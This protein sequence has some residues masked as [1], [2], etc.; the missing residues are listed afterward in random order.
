[1]LEEC[2]KIK[3]MKKKKKIS[4]LNH[5]F[6]QYQI[7]LKQNLDKNI[8]KIV[9][10]S[11]VL[12]NM[13]DNKKKA[14]IVGNGG[15]SAIASH[16]S[17][18]LTK[19]AKIRCINF[20]EADLITCFSNDFGYEKWVE[21]SIDFYGDQGDILFAISTSG[22]SKNII[23]G[24]KAAKRKKF[25]K[26]ITLSGHK[27]NNTLKKQGDINLWLESKAYNQVESIHQIWLLSI[28][29]LMIGKSEYPPN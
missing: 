26:I 27:K 3:K 8:N 11:E 18:D 19:N 5:Y 21:K 16:F 12:K 13:R 6:N 15:S 28:I 20:N 14:I 25:G 23:N 4:F 29:D 24:C 2:D 9:E 7:Y 22:L 1:M 10:I 17:V